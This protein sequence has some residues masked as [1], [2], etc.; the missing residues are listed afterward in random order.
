MDALKWMEEKIGRTAAIRYCW[1][2][3][4]RMSISD[5]G[6]WLYLGALILLAEIRMTVGHKNQATTRVLAA[7]AAVIWATPIA[8]CRDDLVGPYTHTIEY[9]VI[10]II[11]AFGFVVSAGGPLWLLRRKNFAEARRLAIAALV[12]IPVYVATLVALFFLTY[13]HG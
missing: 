1:S 4:S 11:P 10:F 2:C 7:F 3:L 6:L 5:V 8:V 13:G 12:G 9:V